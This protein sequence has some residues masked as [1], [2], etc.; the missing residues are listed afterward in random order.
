MAKHKKKVFRNS[1]SG[2]ISGVGSILNIG[3]KRDFPR[4]PG[5]IQDD[6]R[7][8]HSDWETIGNDMRKA[9]SKEYSNFR[10]EK[11]R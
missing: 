9:M 10:S 4:K 11:N 6:I 2:F 1:K 7:A 8:L 3:G 5:T